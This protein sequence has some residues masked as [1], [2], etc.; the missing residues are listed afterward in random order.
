MCFKRALMMSAVLTAALA[1]QTVSAAQSVTVANGVTVVRGIENPTAAEDRRVTRERAG[2]T[3]FRGSAT[4]YVEEPPTPDT[5]PRQI[6]KGGDNLWIYNPQT[7]K[8]TAC[9][10]LNNVYGYPVVRCSTN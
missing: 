7:N 3:V 10:L 9:D 6:I 8:V 5:T 2:V 4:L 1:G